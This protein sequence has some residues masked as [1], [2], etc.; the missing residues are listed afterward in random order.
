MAVAQTQTSL[1]ARMFGLFQGN[2]KAHGKY[3][4]LKNAKVAVGKKLE[5][6]AVTIKTGGA[7]PEL[8][9]QHIA[10]DYGL[11]IIPIRYDGTCTFA[12][13]D[14]DFYNLDPIELEKQVEVE[15][16]PLLVLR[17]KSGG[18]HLLLLTD[19]TTP[20]VT[21]R[22]V[23]LAWAIQLDYAQV[24]DKNGKMHAIEIF[25]KQ[26][27]LDANADSEAGK[28][29]NWI[30][31]P[32]FNAAHTER[33][34]IHDGQKLSLEEFLDV[35]ESFRI[36]AA[37]LAEYKIAEPAP[38]KTDKSTGFD[39][40]GAVKGPTDGSRDNTIVGLIGKLNRENLS[41]DDA[42]EIVR[43]AAERAGADDHGKP[44]TEAKAR[45]RFDRLWD[46]YEAKK[47][48]EAA[49]AF[50]FNETGTWQLV[51]TRD[52][53]TRKRKVSGRRQLADF[54]ARVIKKHQILDGYSPPR[55]EY[56]IELCRA[57]QTRILEKIPP[58]QFH[59]PGFGFL[60]NSGSAEYVIYPV[61][62][63]QQPLRAAIS[64]YSD[65]AEIENV[66]V[67]PGFQDGVEGV[68]HAGRSDLRLQIAGS[69]GLVNLPSAPSG[70]ELQRVADAAL[71]DRMEG[72]PP[73]IIIP[74]IGQVALAPYGWKYLN[75]TN[76]FVGPSGEF[77][78]TFELYIQRFAGKEFGYEDL[79]KWTFT[80]TTLGLL[81]F[82]A[83]NIV[84]VI[85]DIKTAEKSDRERERLWDK[86]QNV[87]AAQADGGG[88]GRSRWDSI[89][90]VARRTT[91]SPPSGG[92]MTSSTDRPPDSEATDSRIWFTHVP[93][94]AI[95]DAWMTKALEVS[96]A[97]D[98]A[99]L[100]AA[101]LAWFWPQR[102]ALGRQF[103][104]DF[105][106]LRRDR[107]INTPQHRRTPDQVA[108]LLLGWRTLL[109]F[110]T[111]S[112]VIDEEYRDE[113]DALVLETLT[114][115]SEEHG[116]EQAELDPV[117]RF[118]T[119]FSAALNGGQTFIADLTGHAPT[120]YER[121]CGYHYAPGQ[122]LVVKSTV[123]KRP[124]HW[125][126]GS[127]RT[128]SGYTDGTNLYLLFSN[129]YRV[130][131]D[132][133]RREGG[134]GVSAR[135]LLERMDRLIQS[136]DPDNN[137]GGRGIRVH[138]KE[139]EK[140]EYLK[141]LDIGGKKYVVHFLVA[142]ILGKLEYQDGSY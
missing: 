25:P 102:E 70:A 67:R 1:V 5:G 63:G 87:I 111:E 103:Q 34:A 60:Q 76:L 61:R 77:K 104:A 118:K 109:R 117:N 47:D 28:Y 86:A 119:F 14:L 4:I 137:K 42:W 22:R 85:D 18:V 72:I 3:T 141:D 52:P 98:C 89:T 15:G 43:L 16:L 138:V 115:V 62:G 74:A 133:G 48:E 112:K 80:E 21:V 36:S 121:A 59:R 79:A 56:D 31:M 33:Y 68:I 53:K 32:Y 73:H 55:Y 114:A 40:A 13:A 66:Y 78:T 24:P 82:E 92:L 27:S 23:M 83:R 71:L 38:E 7:T 130:A 131:Q 125:E 110:L 84:L 94:G 139:E 19:G 58:E 26:E 17:S 69:L 45:E 132:A 49:P 105:A 65:D 113:L 10:G 54:T 106:Q 11:G 50:E 39:T 97:G 101:Y 12:V 37:Q 75:F 81:L 64:F 29:G 46:K 127:G 9:R 96:A 20:A 93:R 57:G 44:Y 8:W 90:G 2:P 120:G 116:A 123:T 88:T 6:R 108:N 140:E 129:A 124:G 30:N 51:Y 107:I 35:A 122:E 142:D 128:C 135:T 91:V 126:V 99:A 41:K 100:N 95:T 136:R 134:I